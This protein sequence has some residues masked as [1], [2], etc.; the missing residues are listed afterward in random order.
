MTSSSIVRPASP[1]DDSQIWELMAM[2]HAENG[3]GTMSEPKVRYHLDRC[4]HPERI[5]PDDLGWRGFIGVI[6][7]PSALEGAIMMGIG[8][9]WY[10]DDWT[11]DEFFNF[12]HP[13]HRSSGHSRALI[14]YAKALADRLKT[15]LI[16]G[17]ISNKRTAAKVRLYRQQLSECGSFFVYPPPEDIVLEERRMR[18]H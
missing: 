13:S 5:A 16:I 3:I 7:T 14:S 6:G 2:L 18:S 10:S 8:S 4:L 9:Q 12:V 11:L 17:V 15:K 1:A